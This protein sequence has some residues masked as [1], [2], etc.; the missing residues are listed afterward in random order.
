M[1]T[2]LTSLFFLL[3]GLMIIFLVA[4]YIWLCLRF[5][6]HID[7]VYTWV[8]YDENL[9]HEIEKKQKTIVKANY[10][11]NNELLFSLRSLELYA[12]WFHHIFI[13]VR[14]G[15]RPKWLGAHPKITIIT[16]SQ[17]MPEEILPTFNSLVIESFLHKIPGLCEHF[18]Y[19]NDDMILMNPV[20]KTDF[21]SLKGIPVESQCHEVR[22]SDTPIKISSTGIK[23][24]TK[25]YSF[26]EMIYFN[27]VLLDY[28]FKKEKRYQA[29]H[30]PSQD[31]KSYMEELDKFLQNISF[32]S[33]VSVDHITKTSTKRENYNIARNSIF[34]KYWNIYKYGSKQ[35]VMDVIY[36]EINHLRSVNLDEVESSRDSFLC[37][38][39]SIAYGDPNTNIG[40]DDY[41]RL[42]KIL[43]K[44]F[45]K[46]SVFEK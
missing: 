4:Y 32:N 9:E 27:N 39:N 23:I 41:E 43:Y 42:T 28:F 25:E 18:V 2:L 16:H 12:P 24:K 45:P 38:Q 17:I 26:S 40:V 10:T 14:D 29:Q 7:A 44:K 13:V 30:T 3:M 34:K 6:K 8:E 31:R 1:K 21:F 46:P 11:D 22:V 33:E 19:F 35:K 37:I 36:I 20:K 5:P 15:Q